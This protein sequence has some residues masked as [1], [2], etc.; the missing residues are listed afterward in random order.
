METFGDKVTAFLESVKEQNIHHFLTHGEHAVGT[1]EGMLYLLGL[2][3]VFLVILL[4]IAL[5]KFGRK[6]SLYI[7]FEFF[8]E[9]VYDFF[10]DI[11]WKDE[12]SWIKV[13]ITLLFFII[14]FSNL[15]GMINDL[16]APILGAFISWA[17]FTMWEAYKIPSSDI[18]F[19][20]AM[21]LIALFIILAEQFKFLGL[22][23]FTLEY[24]PIF[25]KN[26]IPYTRGNF[27]AIIDI[28]LFL[29]VKVCDI[30]ISLFLGILDV[31]GHLAKIISL[32]FRLFGN[33]TSWGI[34]LAMLFWGLM[35][36]TAFGAGNGF[37]VVG[38]ILLYVQW[39]LVA[40]IQ[41][42]VFPLLVAIFIK[43]GKA[44]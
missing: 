6:S 17:E 43:V 39:L 19:N 15:A 13:Y 37:P 5:F 29:F 42:L 3:A 36:L 7:F 16:V 1:H 20:V 24:F 31:V 9:K 2:W 12:K 40:F 44:H 22:T 41:A 28:P 11:L 34:L 26:F 23:K 4:F 8:F 32:S 30:I 21:S 27:P 25:W 14:L 33:M 38:P 10:E 18:N 35:G